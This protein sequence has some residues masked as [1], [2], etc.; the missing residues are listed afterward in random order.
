[1]ASRGVASR[2]RGQVFI[3]EE[4]AANFTPADGNGLDTQGLE[5]VAFDLNVRVGGTQGDVNVT[6]QHADT[7]VN[8]SY[9]AIPD[10]QLEL[11]IN[12]DDK[13]SAERISI[14][15]GVIAIDETKIGR[16]YV[17]YRGIKRFVR[18]IT[19]GT[20]NT[21]DFALSVGASGYHM[22]HING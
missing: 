10:A 5:A 1:M 13:L 6:L 19:S 8:A 7:D 9:A 16:H 20:A 3:V 18:A 14:S 4:P 17:G 11:S 21:P 15:S 2:M 12:E 22:R